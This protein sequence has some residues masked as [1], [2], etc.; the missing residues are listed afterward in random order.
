MSKLK[1]NITIDDFTPVI[2]WVQIAYV[3]GKR[4]YKRF[5]KWMHGQTVMEGGVYPG[6]LERFL[7]DLPIID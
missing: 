6:D 5:E 1:Q 7:R 4:R 3:L 2:P